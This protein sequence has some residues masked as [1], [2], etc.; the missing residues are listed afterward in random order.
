MEMEALRTEFDFMKRN[1]LNRITDTYIQ[2]ND[3]KK[4]I[5]AEIEELREFQA[6]AA[7][8]AQMAT[9]DGLEPTQ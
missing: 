8:G 3:L 7:M 4:N 5:G 9:A 1:M 6:V 2:F